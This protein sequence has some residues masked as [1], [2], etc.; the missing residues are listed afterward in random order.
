MLHSAGRGV[1]AVDFNPVLPEDDALVAENRLA[2]AWEALYPGE[3]GHTWGVDDQQP[4]PPGRL[5]KTATVEVEAQ[6][7]QIIHPSVLPKREG[8]AAVGIEQAGQ[9]EGGHSD[10]EVSE[11]IPWSDHSGLRC[12]FRLLDGEPP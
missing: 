7:I 1:V 10:G 12:T 3:D 2:D 8:T 9:G 6:E 5:D 4:F 11:S